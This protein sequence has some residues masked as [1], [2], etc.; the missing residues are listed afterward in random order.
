MD[1]N[2]ARLP[3]TPK[4]LGLMVPL[5]PTPGHETRQIPTGLRRV[6]GEGDVLH[7]FNEGGPI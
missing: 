1:G 5:D 2:L 3:D 6:G 7:H 4:E